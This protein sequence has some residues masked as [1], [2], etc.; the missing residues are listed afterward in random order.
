MKL[1]WDNL[2]NIRLNSTGDFLS[3]NTHAY[4][5][6]DACVVCGDPYLM[7]KH[8]PTDLCSKSCASKGRDIGKKFS[9]SHK[10]KLSTAQKR[11]FF[12]PENHPRWKGGVTRSKIT[13]FDTYASQLLNVERT[14]RAVKF[15]EILE[16]VCVYCGRWFVPTPYSVRCRIVALN[17]NPIYRTFGEGR[18]YCSDDCKNSCPT[19]RRHKYPKGFRLATSRE[20]Q[21]E[22]RHIVFKRDGYTCQKCG[23]FDVEIHCHHIDPVSQNPIESADVDNC[24]TLCA[25]CHKNIHKLPG[26]GF[27]ELRCKEVL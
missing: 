17:A 24:I 8:L 1:C 14:R 2:E 5:Y 4:V 10:K 3:T 16:V 27:N 7:N 15:P 25:K 11:R 26:C 9:D 12:N 13:L 22:L 21:P 20:V 19:F 23:K 18:F 6:K